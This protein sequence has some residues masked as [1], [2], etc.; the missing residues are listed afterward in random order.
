M[1]LKNFGRKVADLFK[2][3]WGILLV[4]TLLAVPSYFIFRLLD[5]LDGDLNPDFKY[6]KV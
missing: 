4:F 6:D 3:Y 5:E 1:T 2:N